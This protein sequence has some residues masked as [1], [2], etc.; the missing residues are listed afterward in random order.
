MA[1]LPLYDM[2]LRHRGSLFPLVLL[3]WPVSTHVTS[4]VSEI[5]KFSIVTLERERAIFSLIHI[6]LVTFCV[7][8]HTSESAAEPMCPT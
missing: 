4:T 6:Y 1:R 8:L 2:V 3:S 7:Q 5:F